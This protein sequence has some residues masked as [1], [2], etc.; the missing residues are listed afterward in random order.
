MNGRRQ[1]RVWYRRRTRTS[2]SPSAGSSSGG[3]RRGCSW[4]RP[5]RAPG[6][7]G[8]P[9][10]RRAA[11]DRVIAIAEECLVQELDVLASVGVAVLA[12]APFR[13]LERAHFDIREAID[14]QIE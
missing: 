6:G 13:R 2:R 12:Q 4:R 3:R 9:S 5:A 10:L 1:R 14:L 11:N 7:T 8:A